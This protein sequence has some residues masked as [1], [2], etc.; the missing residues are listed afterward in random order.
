M[1][2]VFS[3]I[4][5]ILSLGLFAQDP[6]KSK[7]FTLD[8]YVSGSISTSTGDNFKQ[9]T[10]PSIEVGVCKNN[11]SFGF[12]TGRLNL[13]KSPYKDENIHNYYYELKASASFSLGSIK[14]YGIIGWGQYY[15]SRHSFLE[16]GG[17]FVYS[18]KHI[19]IVLQVSS[20]DRQMYL[21]PGI[22]YNFKIR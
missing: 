18:I 6:P 21:S 5:L 9:N 10:Y 22:V 14:G 19:D 4:L 16:Y 13:D 12:N 20:W 11:I 15:D 1:K 3:S 2:K 8:G 7:H 17:G